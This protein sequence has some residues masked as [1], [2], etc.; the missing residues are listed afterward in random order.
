MN[1]V[2]S[3][4]TVQVGPALPG[5]YELISAIAADLPAEAPKIAYADWLDAHNDSRASF[6]RELLKAQRFLG[7]TNLPDSTSF[8]KAWTCILGVPL[9]QGIVDAGLTEVKD[10]ILAL[11]R[12][13]LSITTETVS[14]DLVPLGGSKFGGHPDLPPNAPWPRCER[15]P[16]G[17]L[18]QISL[19][20]LKQTQVAHVLPPTGL[21]SVFAYQNSET[22]FQPGAVDPL[23]DST[24]VLYTPENRLL[25]RR[26]PPQDL[27]RD[28]GIFPTCRLSMCEAWDL[29]SDDLVEQHTAAL[30]EQKALLFNKLHEV[31]A[32]CQSFT[33]QLLGYSVHFRSSEPSPG[34]NWMNL[35]CLDSDP[36][37]G[38]NWADDEH[39][40]IFVHE[41]DVLDRTFERIFGYA[42]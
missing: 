36:N 22:R 40:S 5:E 13:M 21:L 33:H 35:I 28:N 31:R 27:H 7:T 11:A 16:L 23:N 42:A 10:A 32:K 30:G 9:L 26:Q 29:P 19:A 17:F 1:L 18:G 37:L 14:E 12:P 6:V 15:G 8:P 38:W 2:H 34:N 25:E 3:V 20:E 4:S 24:R 41:Q 39:L